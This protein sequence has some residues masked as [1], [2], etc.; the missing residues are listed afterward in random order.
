[1]GL[2]NFVILKYKLDIMSYLLIFMCFL[3][4]TMLS[5]MFI[6][7]ILLVA[8]RKRLFDIPDERKIHEKE[9]PRLGGISFLPSILFS[10]C[11]ITG[12]RY[13]L[14]YPIPAGI[15]DFLIPEFYLLVCGLILLYLV[16][17]KDDLVGVYS[18]SKLMVQIVAACLLPLSG[19]WINNLYGLLGIHELTPWVGIPLTVLGILFIINAINLIDGIDGLASG[20]SSIPLLLFG[21][22]FLYFDFWT[23]SML[24]FATLGVLIPFFYYN[25]FGK[26]EHCRKIFM[27]D[28]G[29][30]T[31]GYLLA[32]LAIRYVVYKPEQFPSSDSVLIA[33]LSTL[34]IPLFDVFRVIFLRIRTSRPLFIADKNH[35]H[36][37][38]LAI[39]FTPR[40]ALL[41]ILFAGYT[42]C[43]VNTVLSFYVSCNILLAMDIAVYTII[44]M[45]LDWVRDKKKTFE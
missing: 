25:V 33:A 26:A 30:L 38:L 32:F 29:S 21:I 2:T 44:N 23:Y 9:V 13:Q 27:G 3:I 15:L 42:F 12:I 16:G 35:I 5:S 37:K 4:A 7:R 8:Y 28:T 34:A 36:H 1:M 17:I 22:Q 39:G 11:F 18:R 6:P 45:W 40:E 43:L 20:L 10:L 14:G 41:Y 19:L 24:A 31:L